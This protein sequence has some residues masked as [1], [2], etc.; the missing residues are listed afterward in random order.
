MSE[1]KGINR[2]SFKQPEKTLFY[3]GR[4]IDRLRAVGAEALTGPVIVLME[5]LVELCVEKH[6][7]P[8]SSKQAKENEIDNLLANLTPYQKFQFEQ[9]EKQKLPQPLPSPLLLSIRFV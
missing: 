9:M 5:L 8:P 4:L 1:G 6:T 2:A 3:L 7:T